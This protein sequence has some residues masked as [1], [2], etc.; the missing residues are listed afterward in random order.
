MYSS[1]PSSLGKTE[2][3]SDP[4]FDGSYAFHDS[5]ASA[6][7]S[8][9]AA[10]GRGVSELADL[11]GSGETGDKDQSPS[12]DSAAAANALNLFEDFQLASSLARMPLSRLQLP[13]F[14]E[15]TSQAVADRKREKERDAAEYE[16]HFHLS[17]PAAFSQALWQ[18]HEQLQ[19][20]VSP[21]AQHALERAG[22]RARNKRCYRQALSCTSDGA[23][24][25]ES[26]RT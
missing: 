1:Y 23:V 5:L 24:E 19:R 4:C 26:A 17:D 14:H 20:V 8:S 22:G 7:I 10:F 9:L 15:A 2:E 11:M 12:S 6:I 13:L 18:L 25:F 21:S 3:N 16:P